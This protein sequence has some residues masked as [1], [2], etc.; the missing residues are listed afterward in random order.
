[1]PLL[2]SSHLSSYCNEL[3]NSLTLL[4][5]NWSSSASSLSLPP[6]LLPYD[7]TEEEG[8][9]PRRG[10]QQSGVSP[11]AFRHKKRNQ[12]KRQKRNKICLKK[13]KA[14][15]VFKLPQLTCNFIFSSCCPGCIGAHKSWMNWSYFCCCFYLWTNRSY[16]CLVGEPAAVL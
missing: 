9:G 2:F 12:N 11:T 16:L 4:V 7:P 13:C 8:A 14:Q 6:A 15:P 5:T 3:L 10:L 1:M